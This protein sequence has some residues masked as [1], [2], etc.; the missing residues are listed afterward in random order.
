NQAFCQDAKPGSPEALARANWRTIEAFRKNCSD[1]QLADDILAT[2]S[3]KDYRDV[4]LDVLMDVAQHASPSGEEGKRQYVLSPRVANERLT[5]CRGALQ[6]YFRGMS[7]EQLQ[8]WVKDSITVDETRNPQHLCM[9]PLGV[10]RHRTCDVVVRALDPV[11][12]NDRTH[13]AV[14]QQHLVFESFT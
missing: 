1:K 13:A 4:T 5:P 2:L 7:A 9:S 6:A 12:L 3:K 11:S 8:Q 10:L 14:Q